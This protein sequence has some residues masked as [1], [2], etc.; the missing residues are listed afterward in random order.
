MLAQ[1]RGVPA[2]VCRSTRRNTGRVTLSVTRLVHS[3]R[4]TKHFYILTLT[5]NGSP[6]GMCTSLMHVRRRRKLDFHGMIVFG[7]CRCCPLTPG[8]V[9]DGFGTLGRVLVSRISVSGRGIFAPSD[10]VTGST[11]FRC[12]HLC[13]RHVR[14]FNN[15]SVTLLNVNH[16]NGVNFGR[17][18]SHLGSAA[19]LVLLSGSSHGRT[20]GVFNDVRGAPVDSVAVK[21]TAVLSTG[22]VCL[23][24]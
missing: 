21:M 8:T 10:A 18:N 16:M 17:P 19:H 6:H 3:G 5:N 7:L 22:G 24:T 9:G 12:Y 23:L 1:L 15:L 2:S 13:R 4:G 20:S 14:D 11:V